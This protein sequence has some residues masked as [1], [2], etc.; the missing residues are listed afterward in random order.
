MRGLR[1]SKILSERQPS[2]GK[3]IAATKQS[4]RQSAKHAGKAGG[5]VAENKERG[6]EAS[7]FAIM[8]KNT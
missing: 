5:V 4:P 2:T 8:W 7:T 6:G 1:L 3:H